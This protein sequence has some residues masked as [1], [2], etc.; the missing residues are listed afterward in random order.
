MCVCVFACLAGQSFPLPSDVQ[1]G[2]YPR[3]IGLVDKTVYISSVEQT[4]AAP[5]RDGAKPATERKRERM[6]AAVELN[7]WHSYGEN[8]IFLNKLMEL[9]NSFPERAWITY[10]T[11]TFISAN[12][13]CPYLLK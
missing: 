4:A 2:F 9:T 7:L 6:D 10:P 13:L 5:G 11:K 3:Y 12:L 8:T 1:Y